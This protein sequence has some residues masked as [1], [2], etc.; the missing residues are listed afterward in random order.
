MLKRV[1][2]TAVPRTFIG[3]LLVEGVDEAPIKQLCR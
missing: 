1:G 3:G 2:D